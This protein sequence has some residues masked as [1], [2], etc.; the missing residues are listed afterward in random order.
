MNYLSKI[1]I[2]DSYANLP[3]GSGLR[4][5]NQH[6][7]SIEMEFTNSQI[8]DCMSSSCKQLGF[9]DLFSCENLPGVFL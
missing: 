2:F 1:V 8:G 6:H 4:Y 7:N 5:V 9:M 3:E